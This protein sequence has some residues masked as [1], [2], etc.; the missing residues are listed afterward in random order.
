MEKSESAMGVAARLWCEPTTER[1]GFRPE[2]A[3]VIAG[4]VDRYHDLIEGAW[5]IIANAGGGDWDLATPEWRLAALRWRDL[6][7][8]MLDEDRRGEQT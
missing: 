3:L 7:H 1:I 8:A 5:G 2:L 4:R 6:Y